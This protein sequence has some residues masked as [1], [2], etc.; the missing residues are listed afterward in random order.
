MR[1]SLAILLAAFL[2][3]PA[4][5]RADAFDNYTNPILAKVPGSKLAEPIK[6]LTPELMV[7]HSRALPGTTAALVV[8][9]TNDGRLA[10]LLVRPAAHKLPDGSTAPIVYIERLV[11]FREGEDRTV[12]ASAHDLRLFDGFSFSLDIGQ[13]VPAKLGGDFRCAVAGEDAWLEPVGKAEMFIVTKHFPAANPKKGDKLVVGEKFEPSYFNGKYKL[14]DDGRRSGTLH[15]KVLDNGDVDGHY[16]SD[17]DGSKYDVAGAIGNPK[18]LV[19]FTVSYP[20]AVQTFRGMLFTGDGRVITGTSRLQD[21]ETGFY[22]VR[23][24]D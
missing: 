13:V 8:V 14:Y 21:R 24:E 6:K 7:S 18:H 2:A 20:R 9:K 23:I 16:F 10:K 19:E 15:L 12:V 17:K 5:A 1:R 11:T 3:A 22:A 4:A